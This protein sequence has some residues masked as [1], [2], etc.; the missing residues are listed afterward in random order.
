MKA[1]LASR[2]GAAL[3]LALTLVAC[4]SPSA[5]VAPTGP[6]P[7]PVSGAPPSGAP[8]APGGAIAPV[9][10]VRP[11][12]LVIPS[13]GVQAGPLID[14]GLEDDGSLE[15][16]PD[17]RTAGWFT[18]SPQP[19]DVGPAVIAAHVDYGGVRGPF[20]RLHELQPGAEI[21]VRRADGAEVVFTT[22]RVDRYP[23]SN[24]PTEEVYGDTDGP[25]LRLITCGGVFDHGSGQY[26]DNVVAYARL[27]GAR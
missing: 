6:V 7:A 9:P 13:I 17:A 23:K 20:F 22:Y 4:G 16:P 14:L 3:V 12:A 11:A 2:A 5:A 1:R 25:E 18:F 24:F 8:G 27:V 19:G 15:V 10:A 26:Q 21:S